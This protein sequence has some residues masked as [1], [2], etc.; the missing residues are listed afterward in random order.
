MI[1]F[2][3]IKNYIFLTFE[4]Q[5]YRKFNKRNVNI[6]FKRIK[7]LNIMKNKPI[8]FNFQ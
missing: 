3:D 5:N 6:N 7:A 2:E 8:D 4:K 1:V